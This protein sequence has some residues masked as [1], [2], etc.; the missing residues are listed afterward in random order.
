MKAELKEHWDTYAWMY[1]A[2]F[3]AVGVLVWVY[4]IEEP[5]EIEF[6]LDSNLSI[7]GN[8][9]NYY[10]V[11]FEGFVFPEGTDTQKRAYFFG[12]M[13]SI[14]GGNSSTLII[15]LTEN[16]S[17]EY[18]WD[19]FPLEDDCINESLCFV[20]YRDAIHGGNE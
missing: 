8:I 11:V 5:T 4:G 6:A 20:K 10:G 13:N 2:F 15:N 18:T 16:L 12:W 17:K 14:S 3:V 1:I 19:N 9:E 7:T